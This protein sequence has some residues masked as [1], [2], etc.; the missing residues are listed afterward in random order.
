MTTLEEISS[1]E[2]EKLILPPDVNPSALRDAFVELVHTVGAENLQIITSDRIMPDGQGDY[3]NLPK[4]HDLFYAMDKNTFLAS[5]IV[6]PGSVEETSTIVKVANKYLVPLWPVSRGR[7]LGYG[8]AAPRIRG[9]IVVDLGIRMNRVLNVDPKNATAL[10]EPGVSYFD[11]HNHL[12][13]NGIHHLWIDNP[14][15]GGGSVLGNTLERGAG[16]T[17]YGE[18]F[19]MHCG[20]E[21]VLPNGE[22]IRTGMGALPGNNTW[23]LFQYG[24]GPYHDGIFTQSNLGIVTKMGVWLMPD[25]GGYQAYHFSFPRDDDLPAI[26]EVI[27]DLRLKMIIQNAPTIRNALLDAAVYGPKSQY[28][29]STEVLTEEEVG[30][31]ASKISVGH[32]NVYGALYG[33]KPLRDLQWE[34]VRTAFLTIPGATYRFPEEVDKSSGLSIIHMRDETLKGLPNTYELGW[35]NWRGPGGSL[36]GFSPISPTTGEDANKQYQMVKKRFTQFGF[37]YMGTFVVGWREL[38][39]IVCLTFDKTNP[40][41]RRNAHRCISLLIDD[42]AREGYGEYRTHLCFMDQIA[43]VY[44]WNGNALLKFNETLKDALDPNG[45][46]APGKSGIWPARFRGRGFEIVP[47]EPKL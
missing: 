45:I 12:Q 30:E 20:L 24:Y 38:H 46:M 42:A 36:L 26:V 11:L 25:P 27:R 10:L 31:I 47:E 23:Q 1:I 39:H 3:F 28:T 32:W 16:Y 29:S 5:A 37:D 18:H 22:I 44:N 34:I 7:N 17:P 33:P 13:K 2:D 35:L 15:L 40:T 14:D 19:S 21:V 4:E 8:G 41:E 6:A 43:S 9:S